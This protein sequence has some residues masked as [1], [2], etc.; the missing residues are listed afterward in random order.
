MRE[1]LLLA[2]IGSLLGLIGAIVYG[3]AM[4]FGLRTWWVGAVGTTLL[5][6]HV[7][8]TS[9]VI[10]AVSGI[11]T[12]LLCI[13]LTLRGLRKTSP[14]NLLAGS[15]TGDRSSV[16]SDSPR[17]RVTLSSRL[18][19][20]IFALLGLA[21]LASAKFIGQVGGFFGAGTFLLVALLFFWSAWLKSDKRQ[22]IAGQG[23][24]P[25]AR[26]GFGTGAWCC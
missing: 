25:M 11:V 14:R 9:L 12:A 26:L 13:W 6:L 21:M 18:F 1:G 7:P 5:R 23:F 24:A 16:V 4:M 10:G 22:T 20:I 17:S 3:G 15:V 2:V 8:P 19:A